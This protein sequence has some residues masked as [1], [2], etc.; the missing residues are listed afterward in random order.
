MASSVSKEAEFLTLELHFVFV[1]Y[2]TLL[3]C[4][5]HE[6][7]QVPVMLNFRSSI[8]KCVISDTG[9]AEAFECCVELLLKHVL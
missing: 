4:S 2:H 5:F 6:F 8:Y 3:L 9:D 7:G 1:E